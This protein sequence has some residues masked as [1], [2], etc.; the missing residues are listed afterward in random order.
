[1]RAFQAPTITRVDVT[2]RSSRELGKAKVLDKSGSEI[3]PLNTDYWDSYRLWEQIREILGFKPA[4]ANIEVHNEIGSIV[5]EGAV[6]RGIIAHIYQYNSIE[7]D[8]YLLLKEQTADEFLVIARM[9]V[10]ETSTS[11]NAESRL[12]VKCGTD[13]FV[14]LRLISS[15][16]IKFDIRK[17]TNGWTKTLADKTVTIDPYELYTVGV[18]CGTGFS[19]PDNTTRFWGFVILPDGSKINLLHET[20][21]PTVSGKPNA[22][23]MGI[24]KGGTGDT[25]YHLAAPLI[26]LYE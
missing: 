1:M 25:E 12:N 16:E 11:Y 26:I 21:L 9:G 6:S 10:S 24:Y 19:N 20:L 7:D 23:Y 17:T 2:D 8:D 13:Y 15:G 5:S 22:A 3:T 14:R 4:I 18:Y